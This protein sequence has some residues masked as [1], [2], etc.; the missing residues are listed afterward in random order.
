M[1][2]TRLLA[3]QR[4][5]DFF[6]LILKNGN[7]KLI[8]AP[9]FA[10]GIRILLREIQITPI[11]RFPDSYRCTLSNAVNTFSV[12][13]SGHGLDLEK[14]HAN[15]MRMYWWDGIDQRESGKKINYILNIILITKLIYQNSLDIFM[16]RTFQLCKVR[17]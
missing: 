5:A 6:N 10:A 3:I 8:E 9:Y 1:L 12:M 16:Q 13:V 17:S 11:S 7:L 15:L 4:L 2:Q 14:V